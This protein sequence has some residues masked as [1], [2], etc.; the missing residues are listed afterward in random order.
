M[1][2]ITPKPSVC[3]SQRLWN[4]SSPAGGVAWRI[5]AQRRDQNDHTSLLTRQN[6]EIRPWSKFWCCEIRRRFGPRIE[7]SQSVQILIIMPKRHCEPLRE[8]SPLRDRRTFETD[9]EYTQ[10]LAQRRKQQE[11]LR[12]RQRDRRKRSRLKREREQ[13]ERREAA[14]AQTAAK[15]PPPRQSSSRRRGGVRQRSSGWQH[16]SSAHVHSLSAR[17]VPCRYGLQ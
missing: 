10:Y 8:V 4:V 17:D 1:I 9:N 3:V 7:S 2:G 14:A 6:F 16:S 15:A 12:D 13:A 11:T 5:R